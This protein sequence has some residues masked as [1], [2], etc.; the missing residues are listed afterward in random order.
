MFVAK[1]MQNNAV[2]SPQS[3]IAL[4]LCTGQRLC[5]LITNK[6]AEQASLSCPLIILTG[7]YCLILI[8]SKDNEGII[9]PHDS[10][11]AGVQL[12]HWCGS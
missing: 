10:S 12:G 9:W 3:S 5:Y 2:M 8:D 11:L 4:A 1:K 7:F 6:L